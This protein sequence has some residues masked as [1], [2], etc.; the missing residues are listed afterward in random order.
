MVVAITTLG[1]ALTIYSL[2]SRVIGSDAP[3]PGPQGP[4]TYYPTC[5]QALN[6]DTVT[7]YSVTGMPTPASINCMS[8]PLGTGSECWMQLPVVQGHWRLK[9]KTADTLGITLLST[10]D[11]VC[12]SMPLH[13]GGVLDFKTWNQVDTF[14]VMLSKPL[15]FTTVVELG[16]YYEGDEC[17]TPYYAGNLCDAKQR[18]EDREWEYIYKNEAEADRK[19][20]LL[21]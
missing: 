10:C 8:Y 9:I 2:L 20:L 4:N 1:M 19:R 16:R 11:S 13:G 21:R 15:P 6:I 18:L 14:Y 12:L 17:L 7:L 3:T 5:A